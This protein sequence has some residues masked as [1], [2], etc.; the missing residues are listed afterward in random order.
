[1]NNNSNKN[2]KSSCLLLQQQ[3]QP[4]HRPIQQL[5][6]QQ[7]QQEQEEQLPAPTTTAPTPTQ[8]DSA[9]PQQA[10]QNAS[11][12]AARP[13]IQPR[14]WYHSSIPME[15]LNGDQILGS[16]KKLRNS[17]CGLFKRNLLYF[18]K[19][20][21]SKRFRM[22]VQYFFILYAI[23]NIA[24]LFLVRHLMKK[25]TF[26]LNFVDFD[27][28][29][30][31]SSIY[32]A[33]DYS[34]TVKR[35]HDKMKPKSVKWTDQHCFKLHAID[36]NFLLPMIFSGNTWLLNTNAIFNPTHQI[37]KAPNSLYFVLNFNPFCYRLNH[38]FMKFI[39]KNY[40]GLYPIINHEVRRH[41]NMEPSQP[42]NSVPFQTK[43]TFLYYLVNLSYLYLYGSVVSVLLNFISVIYIDFITFI[44]Q[45][46]M[47]NSFYLIA[48]MSVFLFIYTTL[49]FTCIFYLSAFW[50]YGVPI[51]LLIGYLFGSLMLNKV[52][53]IFWAQFFQ[54]VYLCTF[55]IHLHVPNFHS[56]LIFMTGHSLLVAVGF[57]LVNELNV[58]YLDR[59]TRYGF[60]RN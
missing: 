29:F 3:H 27:V 5:H 42:A 24:S 35:F 17:H 12:T 45:L 40:I 50:D 7:Q 11:A 55:L 60:Y 15:S 57:T 48:G 20:I 32:M 4:R 56:R 30:D 13:T 2:K 6:E 51:N 52:S 49:V 43:N 16:L 18:Y 54:I 8:A 31:V 14:M 26:G 47:N 59:L 23:A 25:E 22:I 36:G 34:D 46:T 1:M 38:P 10:Q 53:H 41:F 28:K 9:A 33:I 58:R 39:F 44:N 19:Q 21:F 37:S